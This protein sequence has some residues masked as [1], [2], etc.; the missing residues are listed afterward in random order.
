MVRAR[1]NTQRVRGATRV[2]S[3][4]GLK[5][6][7]AINLFMAQVDIR[8]DL[9]FEVTTAPKPLLSSTEQAEEWNRSLG[10]Y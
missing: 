3:K 1:V 2:F 4:L 10:E 5:M 6:S 8:G 7:D 9:P